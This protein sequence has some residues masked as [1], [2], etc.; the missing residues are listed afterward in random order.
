MRGY[1]LKIDG[2]IIHLTRANTLEEA[3]SHVL[4]ADH[5]NIVEY[6]T[7]HDTKHGRKPTNGRGEQPVHAN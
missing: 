4:P 5:Q 7:H 3:K 2:E 6:D 1:Y